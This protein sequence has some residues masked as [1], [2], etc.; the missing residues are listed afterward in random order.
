[1]ARS[2]SPLVWEEQLNKGRNCPEG[3]DSNRLPTNADGKF[4]VLFRL[5]W[6]QKPLFD[7]TWKLH[8]IEKSN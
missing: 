6:P 7:E 8:N 2:S 4:V 5:Y 1:M 3:K